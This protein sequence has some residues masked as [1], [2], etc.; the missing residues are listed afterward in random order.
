MLN[1]IFGFPTETL[2][3]ARRTLAFLVKNA[4]LYDFAPMQPFSLEDHT[5]VADEPARFG[6]THIHREDKN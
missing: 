6:I 3:E 1:I 4:G 2:E 5:P